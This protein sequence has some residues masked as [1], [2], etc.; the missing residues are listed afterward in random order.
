MKVVLF[1]IESHFT[2]TALEEALELVKDTNEYDLTQP[3]EGYYHCLSKQPD[4][5]VEITLKPDG[6]ANA[7]CHCTVFKKSKQCKHA[8]AALWLLRDHILRS[9]RAKS[10]SKHENILLGDV[11][12]KL[13][14]TE[15]R[16][17]I[18]SYAQSHSAFRAEILANYLHLIKRPDYHHLLL[19]MT[20]MDKYGQIKL[21]RNN[22]KT[23]RN[24]VSTLLRQA[25]QLLKE[26]ALAEAMQILDAALH[27]LH[28]LMIKVPQFQEQ[29]A[30]ELRLA[31][32]LFD[33]LCH[34]PMAPRLQQN[35]IVLAIDISSREGYSFLKGTKPL[36]LC[37]EP[38]MLEEKTR[39][40]AFRLAEKKTVTDHRQQLPWASM[41][42][43]W[44]RLWSMEA[45]GKELKQILT[46]L[47]PDIILDYSRYEE[48]EDIIFA[49][50]LFRQDQ[51]DK[52]II[53]G[54]LQAGLRAARQTGDRKLASKMAY[55]LSLTFLDQ[56]AWDALYEWDAAD[57][58]RILK[59][60][61]EYYPAGSDDVVDRFLLNGWYATGQQT[62]LIELLGKIGDMDMIV[63]YDGILLKTHRTVLEDIY[64]Q[65]I[66][67]TREMYGGVMARQKL[68]NIFGHL[69]SIDLYAAVLEKIKLMDKKNIDA[70][71]KQPTS[72]RGFVFDLDGVIVDTAVHHFQSWKKV[73][74]ELGADITEEDDHHT[75]GASRMES[76]EYLLN[77]YDIK[78]T[79]QE[80][81]S[82]AAK[83]NDYYLDAIEQITPRDLLPGALAFMIDTRKAGLKLALGSASKNARGVLTKL[84]IE[85]RFD[86]ILDGNDAVESKPHPEIFIKACNSLGLD[87]A[88]VVVFEDA[89]KGV[90]AA[91]AAGCLA[92]GLGDPVTLQEADFVVSGLDKINPS[93][94]IEQLS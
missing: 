78:L 18:S 61:K 94:I 53:K 54:V 91:K 3:E 36:L 2:P 40:E 10:K 26:K 59:V 28:R 63:E 13:T 42:M 70:P 92:V 88:E 56:D 17:F 81:E 74:K 93:L 1:D 62:E 50:G 47:L 39:K 80:K 24:I 23:V 83:K 43:R 60:L 21:N 48:N 4:Y 29:L 9:R 66:H 82:W 19:D 25:Q 49:I 12:K 37:V 5:H 69:R 67:S 75:R 14:I 87:P 33:G 34:Q 77:R 27:H 64:A 45:T 73:L 71:E 51:Y 30:T 41:V 52:G 16:G 72:I 22:L 44:M 55:D 7:K 68:S 32:K 89:S 35:A 79:Q 31:L 85:D 6:I 76:L 90:A 86:A 57:A 15:M 8:I 11:L 58:T 20:P 84:K 38:F 46:R 65:H